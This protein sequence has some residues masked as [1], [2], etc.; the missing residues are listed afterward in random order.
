MC[1][2]YGMQSLRGTLCLF[3]EYSSCDRQFML[4]IQIVIITVSSGMKG[5]KGFALLMLRKWGFEMSH[6]CF[7]RL[8]MALQQTLVKLR[9]HMSNICW[10]LVAWRVHQ[11]L[12]P[13]ALFFHPQPWCSITGSLRSVWIIHCLGSWRAVSQRSGPGPMCTPHWQPP[14]INKNPPLHA[15][16]ESYLAIRTLTLRMPRGLGHGRVHDVYLCQFTALLPQKVSRKWL[17]SRIFSWWWFFFCLL[18]ESVM[19]CTCI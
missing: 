3:S 12:Y 14:L 7:S 11:M 15:W 19:S 13:T 8:P 9:S 1:P 6:L 2:H 4:F 5:R 17:S 10:P 16:R 18:V